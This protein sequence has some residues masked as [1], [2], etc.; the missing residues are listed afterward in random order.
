[1]AEALSVRAVRIVTWVGSA[2][3][4][5]LLAR[6]WWQPAQYPLS[7]ARDM[8]CTGAL[9]SGFAI[10]WALWTSGPATRVLIGAGLA[11]LSVATPALAAVTLVALPGLAALRLATPS[12]VNEARVGGAGWGRVAAWLVLP[13]AL[14]GLIYGGVLCLAPGGY[15]R[16]V[17]AALPLMLG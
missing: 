1:L 12:M 3:L 17:A 8:V 13:A 9:A 5:G 15:W 10:A 11:V 6:P 14:P 16:L 7:I 4:L 2:V